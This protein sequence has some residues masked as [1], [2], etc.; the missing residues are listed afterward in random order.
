ML[1]GTTTQERL[2]EAAGVSVG[3]VRKLER[4]G[5][6]SLPSLL[7][8]VD[9]L[10]TDI[11][12]L[13]GQQAPRRSTDGGERAAPPLVSGRPDVDQGPVV[14]VVGQGRHATRQLWEA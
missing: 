11:A 7:S 13:L 1:R 3:V 12:A 6:A 10:G 14:R 5:T 9:A 8:V 2:A 4:G